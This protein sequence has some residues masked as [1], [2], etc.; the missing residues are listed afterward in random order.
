MDAAAMRNDTTVV[1]C[2]HDARDKA[3]LARARAS[4]E[5][6]APIV[7]ADNGPHGQRRCHW[8]WWGAIYEAT[9]PLVAL[10]F[11]DDWWE[12]GYV[13]TLAAEL[14]DPE[15]AYAWS[16]GLIHFPDGRTRPNL[17]M[18]AER[19]EMSSGE[20][21]GFLQGLS[22][23][24]ASDCIM[25]R[26]EDALTCLLPGGAPAGGF[27]DPLGG[28]DACLALLPLMRPQY[29]RVI[30][31]GTPLVHLGAG[32]DSCTIDAMADKDKN[33]RLLAGYA[34]AREFAARLA[35]P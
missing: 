16:N 31:F 7:I 27:R 23:S 22:Y 28:V 34:E 32:P 1:L 26:R 25:L 9:T 6:Q 10:L 21:F 20:M 4:A 8:T 29:Q 11:D 13:A 5:A 2:T 30:A 15:V 35:R 19:L 12:P 17:N 18:P 14:A 3:L 33:A 24:L